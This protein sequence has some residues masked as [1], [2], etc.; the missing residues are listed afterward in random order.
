MSGLLYLHGFLSSPASSKALA[1]RDWLAHHR[2][3]IAFHCPLLSPHPSEAMVQI[4]NLLNAR[5]AER[6]SLMGSSLGGFW[7]TWAAERYD[8][9]AVLINPLTHGDILEPDYVDRPLANYHTGDTCVLTAADAALLRAA[10]VSS[11]A[12]PDNYLLLAQ[13]GDETLDYRLAVAKYAGCRQIIERGG[14]HGFDGFERHIP[15]AIEF[16]TG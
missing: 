2:P 6:M 15:T 1:V 16:L 7:A 10:E 13:E 9:R 14:S 8:L 11:I 12:R 4:E 3:D 5:P